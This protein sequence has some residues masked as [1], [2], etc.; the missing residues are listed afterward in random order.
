[1][2]V[3]VIGTAFIS[4]SFYASRSLSLHVYLDLM[5]WVL[6]STFLGIHPVGLWNHEALD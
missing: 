6:T 5:F 4:R 2:Y 3:S 1:M